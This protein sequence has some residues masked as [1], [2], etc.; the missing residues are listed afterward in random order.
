MKNLINKLP[1]RFKWTIHNMI[2][3]PLSELAFQL[4][5]KKVSE[6][7]HDVTTPETDEEDVSKD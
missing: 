6:K 7:I 4:G 5:M 2:G 1:V 3:H